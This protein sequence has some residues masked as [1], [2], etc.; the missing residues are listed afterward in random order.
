[1]ETKLTSEF[2]TQ[3]TEFILNTSKELILSNFDNINKCN[4]TINI[5][6]DINIIEITRNC[7]PEEGSKPYFE[8]YHVSFKTIIQNQKISSSFYL[9][10]ENNILNTELILA[11]TIWCPSTGKSSERKMTITICK[12]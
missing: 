7:F 2:K 6:D 10:W 5:V 8:D 11:N 12:D 3:A 4:K 9:E 1:M